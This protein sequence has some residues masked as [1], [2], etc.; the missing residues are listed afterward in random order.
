MRLWAFVLLLFCCDLALPMTPGAYQPFEPDGQS[1]EVVRLT[2]QAAAAQLPPLPHR[3]PATAQ[4]APRIAPTRV[5][6]HEA[7]SARLF[8]APLARTPQHDVEALNSEDPA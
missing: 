7:T 8:V 5:V 2:V 1:V 6:R 4:P 3:F